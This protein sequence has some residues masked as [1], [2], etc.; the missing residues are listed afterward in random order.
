MRRFVLEREHDVSGVSG[1]GTVAEGVEF[2]DGSAVV[3]WIVGEHQS[4]VV[5]PGSDAATSIEAIHGHGGHT[6]VK[7]VDPQTREAEEKA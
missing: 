6:R 4:I 3:K 1:T 7:W 2:S 5:W